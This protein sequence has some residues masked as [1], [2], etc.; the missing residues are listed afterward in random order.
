MKPHFFPF[1]IYGKRED[2]KTGLL[3][4][5]LHGTDINNGQ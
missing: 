2:K 3:S 5:S 4:A 1:L